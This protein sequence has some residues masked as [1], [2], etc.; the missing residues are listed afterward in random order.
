MRS[1]AALVTVLSAAAVVVGC[2]S[3]ERARRPPPT[4]GRT[5]QRAP[6]GSFLGGGWGLREMRPPHWFATAAGF[7]REAF[8]A[9]QRAALAADPDS[10][11]TLHRVGE[12]L[13]LFGE[14]EEGLTALRQAVELEPGD[15][16]WTLTYAAACSQH[17]RLDSAR[18]ALHVC[19]A[20]NPANHELAISEARVSEAI[21]DWRAA[22]ARY[23]AV[24]AVIDADVDAA[25]V[26][27]W[28]RQRARCLSRAQDFTSARAAYEECVDPL[29]A[30][31]TLDQLAEYG[32][33]CLKCEDYETAQLL[34]DAVSRRSPTRSKPVE[35]LR[36]TC[37]IHRGDVASARNITTAAQSAWPGDPDLARLDELIRSQAPPVNEPPTS[38]ETGDE[39]PGALL[40]D[41][42]NPRANAL[43]PE[44]GD[45]EPRN[46]H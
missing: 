6:L 41:D 9:E 38:V 13:V 3:L 5:Y 1:S 33:A 43:R 27:H 45:V 12:A 32:N 14:T 35:V 20:L 23:A 16:R 37:A 11:E 25:A 7:D 22:A 28:K 24:A 21:G 44:S 36:A 31:A 2:R 10:A 19:A 40:L 46:A 26:R 4:S 42:L 15:P 17:G 18:T 34:F 30:G 29:D 8:L 39:E